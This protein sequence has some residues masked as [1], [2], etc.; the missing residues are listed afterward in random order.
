MSRKTHRHISYSLAHKNAL[1]KLGALVGM[2]Q[3]LSFCFFLPHLFQFFLNCFS[4]D[5]SLAGISCLHYAILSQFL[6]TRWSS[7]YVYLSV[8]SWLSQGSQWIAD[9][10]LVT[11]GSELTTLGP[12][13][14]SHLPDDFLKSKFQNVTGRKTCSADLWKW[15]LSSV[16]IRSGIILNKAECLGFIIWKLFKVL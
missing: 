1:H 9:S 6:D 4:S 8:F 7:K 10:T 11:G 12:L 14:Q 2:T 15:V 5:L 13:S 3:T 16:L